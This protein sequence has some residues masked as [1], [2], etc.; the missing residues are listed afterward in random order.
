[1]HPRPSS[2]R[3]SSASSVYLALM[4][5]A[6]GGRQTYVRHTWF[7]AWN[8]A[9]TC[10]RWRKWPVAHWPLFLAMFWI[11]KHQLAQSRC[12]SPLA[13]IIAGNLLTT[14]LTDAGTPS[15][16]LRFARW[17]SSVRAPHLPIGISIIGSTRVTRT[18]TSAFVIT[19]AG[20]FRRYYPVYVTTASDR[21]R[22]QN[23]GGMYTYRWP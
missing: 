2:P 9:A 6:H 13:C 4:I 18:V 19:V 12:C 7:F 14:T 22:S 8:R 17:L 10:H 23:I 15:R 1:M 5:T 21:D 20:R 3:V 16:S 11:N